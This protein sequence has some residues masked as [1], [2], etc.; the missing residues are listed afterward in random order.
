MTQNQDAAKPPRSK[1]AAPRPD[2]RPGRPGD[3]SLPFFLAIFQSG[4][5]GS[6]I[7]RVY[8]CG[9]CLLFIDAGPMVAFID[10]RM[11]RKI[12]PTH[13]AVKAAGMLKTG[14]VACVGGALAVAGLLFR[15]VMHVGLEDA[16]QAAD[17][18]VGIGVVVVFA[19]C[20]LILALTTSVRQIT[21]RVAYLDSLP[22]DELG[23]EADR[24]KSS[25]R[26]TADDLSDVTID[27]LGTKGILGARARG[28]AARLSFRYRPT[29]K[30]KLN[31]VTA[32]D[33]K[34]A[35][36]AFRRLLGPGNVDVNAE[37]DQS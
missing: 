24:G 16:S 15:I 25:F 26:A 13:W 17:L 35:V 18:A 20:L 34:A 9:D 37:V 5:R 14:L 21:K 10:V 31:L 33:T 28:T 36:R 8:P 30:W 2:S 23:A 7:L 22:E 1:D 12:D 19:L 6:R 32:K 4:W 29:G 3:T 11:A 27:P